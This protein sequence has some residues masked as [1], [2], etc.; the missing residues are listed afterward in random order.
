MQ[1]AESS[2]ESF[3]AHIF[4]IVTMA[5]HPQGQT[6]HGPAKP[7]DQFHHGQLLAR[8]APLHQMSLLAHRANR[9]MQC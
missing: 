2:E 3:L 9:P 5:E 6:K 8:Q 4:G 7:I 1:T